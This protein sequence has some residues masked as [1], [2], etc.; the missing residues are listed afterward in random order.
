[1]LETRR[2]FYFGFANL[3]LVCSCISIELP[4]QVT[5][6][7]TGSVVLKGQMSASADSSCLLWVAENG[8]QFVL[9]QDARIPNDDFDAVIVPGTN[10]RL[11]LTGR[12]DLGEPCV[13]DAENAE[14]IQILEI[15]GQDVR[16]SKFNEVRQ[17]V[18][19]RIA[20]TR[21]RLEEKR[22]EIAQ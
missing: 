1:M 21:S 9:F 14:V 15:E 7:G 10:S 20:G 12:P 2:L 22:D 8:S 5:F 17:H 18:D 4:G 3:L 13:V 19:D 11:E 6:L 16:V